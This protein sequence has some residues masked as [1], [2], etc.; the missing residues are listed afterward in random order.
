MI[1]KKLA[2]LISP[3]FVLTFAFVFVI[4]Y[5]NLP[6]ADANNP[7]PMQIQTRSI[8]DD[9][10]WNVYLHN[11]P[12]L[13]RAGIDTEAKAREHWLK[14]G[15]KEG[16]T[17]REIIASP[18]LN[19]AP[20]PRDFD[21][22]TY[23]DNYGDLQRNR[24]DTRELAEEHWLKTGMKEGRTY[25][26]IPYQPAKVRPDFD[27]KTYINNYSDLRSLGINTKEKAVKHWLSQGKREGRT[28]R[29]ILATKNTRTIAPRLLPN[30]QSATDLKRDNREGAIEYWLDLYTKQSSS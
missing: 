19:E 2:F 13:G 15:Q 22:Q 6:W 18:S 21:W 29:D 7:V 20:L 3:V 28:C 27:W 1:S 11:Y 9:F 23:V 5:E 8:P 26:K 24:V 25:Y 10:A 14:F 17:Y 16:R 12:D 4:R 30:V